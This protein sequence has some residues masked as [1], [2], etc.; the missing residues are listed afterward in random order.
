MQSFL[1]IP[2]I[3]DYVHLGCTPE[4]RKFQ[5]RVHY[6]VELTFANIP[7][8]CTTDSLDNT[9]CYAEIAQVLS[10]V[11]KEKHYATIEHLA[12]EGMKSVEKY[13]LHFA[14][15]KIKEVLFT[16][17]KLNPPVPALKGGSLFTL[18][19]LYS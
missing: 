17:H 8:A 11:S 10:Q 16:V 2:A 13:V 14:D 5:H 1:K 3:E 7:N 9:P 15:L 12:H 18:R 6:T 4:E 19:Q